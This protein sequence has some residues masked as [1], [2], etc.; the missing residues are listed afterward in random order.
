MNLL[1]KLS[2]SGI[3]LAIF[4]SGCSK[5]AENTPASPVSATEFVLNTVSTISIYGYED[6]EAAQEVIDEAF[7]VCREYERLLSRTAEG[8]D[9]WNIN[10][11]GGKPVK[12]SEDTLYLLEL[13]KEYGDLSGGAFDVTLGKISEMWDFSGENPSV[14]PAEDIA[15]AISHTGYENIVISDEGVYL[16]DPEAHVDLGGIAKGYTADKVKEFLMEEDVDSAIINLG[17]NILAFGGKPSENGEILPFQIGVSEPTDRENAGIM[18]YFTACDA[19]V[20][21]S[22]NYE[23]YFEEGGVRYHHILDSETGYPA[24]TGLDSVTI[25]SEKSVDGDALSTTCFVLGLER[26]MELI[27]SIPDTEAV[28]I[29]SDGETVMTS[30]AEAV[31]TVK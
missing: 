12:V 1:K 23:R 10:H 8:S 21:T 20:V 25:L 2:V 18:G 9:V 16:A 7:G 30:G 6:E 27:E 29:T 26:A 24:E 11:S 13:S 3:I 5:K 4:L 31:Y 14:P 22:G 28:F 15:E 17:G 19:S